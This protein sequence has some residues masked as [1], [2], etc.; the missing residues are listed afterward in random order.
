MNKKVTD[1]HREQLEELFEVKVS[2]QQ[3]RLFCEIIH[4]RIVPNLFERIIHNSN[5]ILEGGETMR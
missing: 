2:D 3:W 4:E 5:N 1:I